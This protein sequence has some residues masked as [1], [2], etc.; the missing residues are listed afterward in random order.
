MLNAFIPAFLLLRIT[1][2]A[3]AIT[4]KTIT[5]IPMPIPALAPTLRPEEGEG[6][7]GEPLP[8][9]LELVV[10]VFDVVTV[11]CGVDTVLVD[12]ELALGC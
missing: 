7:S 3:A 6:L 2:T 11:V 9:R 5:A 10:D 1:R 12:V 8:L 4:L